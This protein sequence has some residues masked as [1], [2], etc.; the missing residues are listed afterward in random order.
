M[1]SPVVEEPDMPSD[2]RKEAGDVQPEEEIKPEVSEEEA[3]AVT[4]TTDI[5]GDCPR[6]N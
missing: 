4:E 5:L 6:C 2:V 1:N 3:P